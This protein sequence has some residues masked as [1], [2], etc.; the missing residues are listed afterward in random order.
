MVSPSERVRRLCLVLLIACAPL[1]AARAAEPEL[2]PLAAAPNGERLPGKFIW[3]D[4]VTGDTQAARAFYALL[5]GWQFRSFGD[6][7]TGYAVAFNG[8]RPIGGVVAAAP[9]GGSPGMPRWVGYISVGDVPQAARAI[10]AAGGRQLVAPRKLPARA[11]QAVFADPEGTVFGIMRSEAG[12]PEDDLAEPGEW[13]WIQLLT[14]D[15]AKATAFYRAVA[16]YDVVENLQSARANDVLLV[17]GEFARAAV[18][19]LPPTQPQAGPT[20]LPFVRVVDLPATLAQAL[21]LSGRI[22]VAPNPDMFDGRI[23][24]ITDPGGAL[25]GLMQWDY[26]A[27]EARKR[28]P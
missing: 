8:D 9:R 7:P 28:R 16:G 23:A 1:A 21:N 22:L 18:S 20:W 19:L 5:F 3:A 25:I 12:D 4:L 2:P 17:K 10:L 11:E 6:G 27:D 14:R 13:I 15:M 26:E 24:V